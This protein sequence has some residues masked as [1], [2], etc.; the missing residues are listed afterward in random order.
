VICTYDLATI[1]GETVID[2]IR[3]HPMVII[4]G[5]LQQNPFFV[6]PEEFLR[7][8]RDRRAKSAPAT[9]TAT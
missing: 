1:G 9:S 4:G 7:E 2:I 6:P 5:V 3:T 8:L